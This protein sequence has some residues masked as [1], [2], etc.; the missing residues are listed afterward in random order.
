MIS[1]HELCTVPVLL[2][3][4]SVYFQY[5]VIPYLELCL[6][7]GLLLLPISLT[8]TPVVWLYDKLIWLAEPVLLLAEVVLVQNFVMRC[9]QRV[10]DNIDDDDENAKK[11]KV[12]MYLT[13]LLVIFTLFFFFFYFTAI[14][15][16]P[17]PHS[18]IPVLS[19]YLYCVCPRIMSSS[20]YVIS[21]IV[22]SYHYGWDKYINSLFL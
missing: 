18:L 14:T 22:S 9:G 8:P 2:E 15:P 5:S 13:Y 20:S 19:L 17:T 16:N 4:L 3:S 11:W 1:H 10:A 12:S 21:I 7:A 6:L